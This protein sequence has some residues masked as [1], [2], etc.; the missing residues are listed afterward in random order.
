MT[1]QDM[2]R[3]EIRVERMIGHINGR[4]SF[5]NLSWTDP[6]GNQ[7][8][9]VPHGELR[10]S[11]WDVLTRNLNSTTIQELTLDGAEVS[12]RLAKDMS[13]DFIRHTPSMK[14]IDKDSDA[15]LDKV[16]LTGLSEEERKKIGEWKR[17]RQRQKLTKQWSNFNRDG[18]KL[19][20]RLNLPSSIRS[21]RCAS[22][23]ARGGSAAR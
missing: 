9:L 10:V 6:D 4:V 23:R 13:V 18:R 1:Q 15:W 5:D 11:L 12:V 7:L 19:R 20:L 16:S 3:G 2:L 17:E 14:K 21:A 22:R 8:L